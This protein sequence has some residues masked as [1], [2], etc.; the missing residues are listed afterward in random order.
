[1]DNKV[2]VTL[3]VTLAVIAVIVSFGLRS[4]LEYPKDGKGPGNP[5]VKK[6]MVRQ[7]NQSIG[8][9]AKAEVKNNAYYFPP[10]KKHN[11]YIDPDEDLSLS[12]DSFFVEEEKPVTDIALK[13]EWAGDDYVQVIEKSLPEG[14]AD[15]DQIMREE[16]NPD[17]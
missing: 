10:G 8:T 5:L 15:I 13:P 9:K 17:I 14:E 11:K 4:A 3:I 7:K 12:V 1:M 2:K 6:T 16:N